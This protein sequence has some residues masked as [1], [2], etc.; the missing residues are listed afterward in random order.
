ML[1]L[2]ILCLAAS[3]FFCAAGLWFL[4]AALKP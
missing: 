2:N 3:F 1:T 4:R